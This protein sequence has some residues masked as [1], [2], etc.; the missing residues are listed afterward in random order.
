MAN[1]YKAQV[2]V[3]IEECADITTDGSSKEDVGVSER[4]P[5]HY[6]LLCPL[7]YGQSVMT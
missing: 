5:G 6:G 2:R 3:E 4:D 7:H 1:N